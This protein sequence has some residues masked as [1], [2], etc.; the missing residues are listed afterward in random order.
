MDDEEY[1]PR[2][3]VVPATP[4][5]RPSSSKIGWVFVFLLLT[6][7]IAG[8]YVLVWKHGL[9]L[10][11]IRSGTDKQL[12]KQIEQID[13]RLT[14]LEKREAIHARAANRHPQSASPKTTDSARAAGSFHIQ[15]FPSRGGTVREMPNGQ[16]PEVSSSNS[17]GGA[18]ATSANAPTD[19]QIWEA[20]AD[21]LGD[22]VA[23]LNTQRKEIAAA[24]QR[25]TQMSDGLERSRL[26]F[27]LRKKAR[28]TQIGPVRLQL[29]DTDRKAQRYTMRLFVDDRWIELKDRASQ[30]Q[31]RL[32]VPG[33]RSV[34]WLVVSDVRDGRVEGFLSLPKLAS[35]V[36]SPSAR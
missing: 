24:R 4:V 27:S 8:G 2:T 32:R 29:R 1:N 10:V 21:R 36:L 35:P 26:S 19:G 30:E 3:F 25:I 5:T 15:V 11:V 28:P 7:V 16:L 14:A 17:S 9:P 34:V 13:T 18:G 31:I 12:S 23:E 20:T 6:G 22:A 33:I